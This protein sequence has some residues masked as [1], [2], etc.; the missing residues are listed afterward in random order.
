MATHDLLT[1]LPNRAFFNNR[2][3]HALTLAK[4]NNWQVALLFIDLNGFKAIND[5]FGHT[6]GDAALIEFGERLQTSVR[7]SDTVARFGGDEFACLLENIPSKEELVLLVEKI[8][9]N[10]KVPFDVNEKLRLQLAASIGISIFPQDGENADT[11]LENADQAMYEA[12][13]IK[14][15]TSFYKLSDTGSK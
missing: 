6:V 7:D 1:K 2:M 14:G 10:I 3:D 9:A 13:K 11:L 5:R 12:K 4:R 8:I 15:Q